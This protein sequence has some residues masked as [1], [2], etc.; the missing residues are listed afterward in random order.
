MRTW[1]N[2]IALALIGWAVYAANQSWLGLSGGWAYALAA[3]GALT[4]YSAGAAGLYHWMLSNRFRQLSN[5]G[6]NVTDATI[7]LAQAEQRHGCLVLVGMSGAAVATW[8]LLYH[9]LPW[10]P[11]STLG[12]VGFHLLLP[13]L[14]T[15]LAFGFVVFL[16][17]VYTPQNVLRSS[18]V[19]THFAAAILKRKQASLQTGGQA[20]TEKKSSPADLREQIKAAEQA[21]NA[22]QAAASPGSLPVKMVPA[23]RADDA[24]GRRSKEQPRSPTATPPS[25]PQSGGRHHVFISYSSHD[26][27]IAQMVCTT[28]E[29]EGVRCWIAPRDV[30]PGVP[31]AVALIDALSASRVLVLVFSSK[32]N[33]SPQVNRE[34][35]RA[36]AKGI[37]IIP[38]R[39]EDVALSKSM[40]YY[41]SASHWLDAVTRPLERHLTR[42]ADAVNLLLNK[43]DSNPVSKHMATTEAVEQTSRDVPAVPA[44]VREKHRPPRDDVYLVMLDSLCCVMSADGIAT[45]S[46]KAMIRDIMR[47]LEAPLDADAVDQCIE[48]FCI[49]VANEG[50]PAVVDAITTEATLFKRME[51][52]KVLLKCLEKVARADG[53]VQDAET[54]MIERFRAIVS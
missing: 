19:P 39:I 14:A 24:A 43:L 6:A 11:T 9:F 28:L 45:S 54:D 16:V 37:P 36:V 12:A 26:R 5:R 31:Y 15:I 2:L 27:E 25:P 29:G 51:N 40:E 49:R 8:I 34:V 52:S 48:N 53:K 44:A 1:L 17:W 13:V 4:I 41:I 3:S 33:I 38:L 46:E 23:G 50:F 47:W 20:S 18:G 22:P 32:S 10:Q 7:E 30:T 35:E 42:L 21:S